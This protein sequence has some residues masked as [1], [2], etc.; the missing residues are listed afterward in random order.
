MSTVFQVM[1]LQVFR[2]YH[3]SRVRGIVVGLCLLCGVLWSGNALWAAP[4]PKTLTP[5]GTSATTKQPKNGRKAKTKS[6]PSKSFK[7]S[8]SKT[9]RKPPRAKKPMFVFSSETRAR[10]FRAATAASDEVGQKQ[11]KTYARSQ[12]ADVLNSVSGLYISQHTGRGKAHQFFLRGFD[13]VHGS[14]LEVRVQGIPINEASNIHGQ[15]YADI[16]FLLPNAVLRLRSLKGPFAGHQG[17]FAI[18]GSLE[19]DLG[20]E[21][22]GLTVYG[23][24]DNFLRRE[25]GVS[26][27][28]RGMGKESFVAAQF[29]ES[30]GFGEGRGWIEG[31]GMAQFQWRIQK[32]RLRL[33]VAGHYGRFGSA[34]VLR[35][36]DLQNGNVGFYDAQQEGLGGHSGRFLGQAT[37]SWRDGP[38]RA[39]VMMY[40]MARDLRLKENF[41]GFLLSE[42]GDTFEQLH[43]FV[44]A[45]GQAKWQRS[46]YWWGLRQRIQTGAEIRY[47]SIQQSQHRL[48]DTDQRHTTEIDA[49]VQTYQLA[50]WGT[51]Q[52]H[53]VRWFYWDVSLRATMLG[54]AVEDVA[55]ADDIRGPT[56]DGAGLFLAP[57]TIL[58][59]RFARRWNLFAAY[60]L[61]F[62]SVQARSLR[63]GERVPF[64]E[65]HNAEVG[66]RFRYK[67]WANVSLAA[68]GV[69]MAQELIFDHATANNLY[70][71]S[72]WRVGGEL[73]F[74]VRLFVPWLWLDTSLTYSEGQLLADGSPIP[75]AP[76]LLMRNGLVMRWQS[77]NRFWKVLLGVRTFVL[78]PRPLPFGFEAD[79]VFQLNAVARVQIGPVFLRLDAQNLLNSQW[80]DGQFVYTSAYE[81]GVGAQKIPQLHYTAGTPFRLFATVGFN[82]F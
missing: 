4:T 6:Q 82:V 23:G 2:M 56:R 38:Q 57:R 77:R 15:G 28:P 66:V 9:R 76:R 46:W 81:K 70:A 80:K 8:K 31:R 43:S 17:D 24:V 48:T 79:T 18:T 75:F 40:A 39:S 78:G 55:S 10:V 12:A 27:G 21:Q 29:A 60:G 19:V 36:F 33:L 16:G 74:R 61:G 3:R 58:R 34:G 1:P 71:G 67:D 49:T 37:L 11:L 65:A 62:R 25:L 45:G 5:R 68:F 64:Q 53:P 13:A 20:L 32:F 73:A 63:E 52:F 72:S 7:A 42:K 30:N 69:Y 44:Q 54:L 22:R 51:F 26:W 50:A 41:T 59:F 47:D 35:E 14:E